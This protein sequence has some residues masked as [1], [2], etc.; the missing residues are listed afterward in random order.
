MKRYLQ[1]SIQKDLDRKVV[2]LSGPRQSGKT[3]LAKM[4]SSRFEYLN[5]D[6]AADAQ[7]I[8]KLKWSRA[9]DLVI[10]DE[11]HKM[12]LWKRFLKGIYDT[13]GVR[14]R[15]LVTGSAR[16]DTFRKTGDSLAG[17]HFLYRCHPLSVAEVHREF[18]TEPLEILERMLLVG[19]F[20]EPYLES[21]PTFVG[22]WRRSHLDRILRED[23]FDLE[24]IRTVQQI[25]HLV[26]MLS[27]QAGQSVSYKSLAS[28]LSVAP[29]TVKHWIQILESLFIVFTLTPFSKAIKKSLRREPRVFFYDTGRVLSDDGFRLENLVACHLLK[30]VHY[31]QDVFGENRELHYLR[32]KTKREVDFVIT[33]DKQIT[34]LIEVKTSDSSVGLG[35]KHYSKQF[36]KAQ[37]IQLVKVLPRELQIDGVKVLRM[38]DW[39]AKELI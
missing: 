9:T 39:L 19:S 20:P 18:K 7:L 15:L 30:W 26:L 5:W 27:E 36:P 33:Q 11:L 21:D 2:I 4:L 38:A 17:R 25:E 24:K 3:T 8:R 13:E 28:D 10:L 12:K 16:M 34:H 23:L 1:D 29:A 32:D 35:L 37:A 14:P 6:S 22:R 31:R